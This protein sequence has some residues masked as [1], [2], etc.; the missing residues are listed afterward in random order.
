MNIPGANSASYTI[1]SVSTGDNGAQFRCVVS[2]AFG[3]ATSNNA[4][5]TV[6]SNTAPT[7]TINTPTAGTLYNAG[8][9]I[10]YSGSATD[11]QD[12]TLPA[13]AFTWQVDFH[14]DT[15]T[16]PFVPATSGSTSGSFVIPTTGET[17][18]NVFYRIILTV[19]DSGGLTH[20]VFRDVTPRTATVTLRTNPAGLQVTLDGQPKTDGYVETNFFNFHGTIV[21]FSYLCVG[22]V[23]YNFVSWSDS[24]AATHNVN[25]PATNTTYTANF[26]RASNA[27]D[28]LI[29]EFRLD[30]P[31]G[32]L[33]EFVELYNNTDADITVSTDDLSSGW[34]LVSGVPN[35]SGGT[36]L[37]RYHLIP[38]GTIIPA[39]GHYLVVGGGYSLQ[40]YGGTNRA[41]GDAV[42][43]TT[44]LGL[45]G[46]NAVND[47]FLG[48]GLF[49][50][51]S[52]YTATTR[53]D[54]VGMGCT[55][56][57]LNEGAG[58]AYCTDAGTGAQA[59][60]NY[61]V[62]RKLLS[63][64]PQ[65]TDD[66]AA[67]FNY[68]SPV[69][70]FPTAGGTTAQAI[71]GA[72]GPENSNSPV[73][74]NATIKAALVDSQVAS[75]APPNRVRNQAAV[76][77]GQFGTLTIRR[78]FTNKTGRTITALR[79][80]LIG[81]TTLGSPVEVSPQADLRL[82][83]STD[84]N[85]TTSGGATVTILGTSLE[86][87]AA[88]S[89]GGGLNSSVIVPLAGGG[90]I[91]NASLNVQFRLG[92]EQNGGFRFFVNV[93]GILAPPAP[94]SATKRIAGKN[95]ERPASK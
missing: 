78:K 50:S 45:Q 57:V 70:S 55:S 92:V 63:G 58:L 71:L 67:D 54:S 13:S 74:R 5:L 27:H 4:T 1:S 19:T 77:N 33:D 46:S 29:S 14:H 66:N 40:N 59:S 32:A 39:R 28:V 37:Q 31:G 52:T 20:Q 38:N 60:V 65:D 25:V 49:R 73:Q 91:N 88:Q 15:H 94:N 17:A 75:S 68:I 84:E 86:E 41:Q 89:L 2:N 51:A 12:G 69:G 10:N 24:G 26:A 81:I 85:I 30:G 64:T 7:A 83:T 76:A 61:S 23:T 80:R 90:L 82:L 35:T 22:G 79:F 42:A 44:G 16:H 62:M 72:P 34:S 53:L 21:F 3:S 93:E 9:T 87:P 36:A 11:T 48:V 56:T 47:P 6:T 95:V 43:A 18:A 8:D